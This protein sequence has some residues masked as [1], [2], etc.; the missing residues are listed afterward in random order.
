MGAAVIFTT[1]VVY[2]QLGNTATLVDGLEIE[3]KAEELFI[4]FEGKAE[5]YFAV[6]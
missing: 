2:M 3:A 1:I 5:V 6:R 4:S